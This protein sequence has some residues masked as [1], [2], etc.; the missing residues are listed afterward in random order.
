MLE[1]YELLYL[2]AENN[3]DAISELLKK[4]FGLIIYK[5]KKYCHKENELDDYINVGISCFYDTI[6]N[7]DD[8]IKYLTYLNKCLD[9]KLSNHRKQSKRKKHEILNNAISLDDII[10]IPDKYLLE[11]KSNPDLILE[12]MDN[13][14]I[15]KD[16]IVNKLNYQEE[17]IFNMLEENLT[18]KE[19]SQIIDKKYQTVYNIIRNIRMKVSKIM[20]N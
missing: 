1:D 5:A 15:I 17:L 11:N 6:Y 13:Y 18:I 20:S 4:Y 9:N 3:E 7:Y 19:I 14:N 8:S 2:A 12:D 16:T 10:N